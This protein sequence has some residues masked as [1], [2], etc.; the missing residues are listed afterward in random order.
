[1]RSYPFLIDLFKNVLQKS[2]AIE[3]RFYV[4]SN[5]GQEINSDV[6]G[7][8]ISDTLTQVQEKKYPIAMMMPPV[9]RGESKYNQQEFERYS[10]SM[11][12]LKTTYYDSQNQVSNPN[13]NT[14][15]SMHT[16]PQDWHDMKR[17]A[18]AFMRVLDKMQ[19]SESMLSY[20]RLDTGEKF[21]KP[22][23]NIG[24]DRASGI[25]LDFQV[26]LFTGC[27]IEDYDVNDISTITIP[28]A[29]PHPEHSL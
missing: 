29:D 16:I 24:I 15:T 13:P 22:V 19:R 25:K 28:V 4:S 23:S 11:F 2:K 8:V 9:S 3:G 21:F 27:E 10:I 26:Q 12:F 5:A 7:Q 6:L 1:M 20:F 18:T 17:C 14:G